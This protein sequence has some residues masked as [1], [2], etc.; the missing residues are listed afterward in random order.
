MVQHNG[1]DDGTWQY[2]MRCTDVPIAVIIGSTLGA[3]FA[4]CLALLASAVVIININDWRQY[5]NYLKNKEMALRQLEEN[6]N[7][8]FED[9][10]MR[11]ENP[12]YR[13]NN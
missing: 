13:P 10:S 9:P 12:A 4:V 1:T 5:Q 2:Q 7:P 11:T 3:F 8:L 6:K